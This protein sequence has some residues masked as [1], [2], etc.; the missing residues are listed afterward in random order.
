MYRQHTSAAKSQRLTAQHAIAW[1]DAE[2]TLMANMLL[3]GNN[4]LLR[5]RQRAQRRAVRLCF[6]FRRMNTALKIPQ[7]LFAKQI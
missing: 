3:Q 5:Q 1:R 2:L 4:K 7:L 6:H